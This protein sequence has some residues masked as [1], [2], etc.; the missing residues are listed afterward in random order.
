MTID[1]DSSG[2]IKPKTGTSRAKKKKHVDQSS[3]AAEEK[4]HK[5]VEKP[6]TPPWY[7]RENNR[8]RP[9]ETNLIPKTMHRKAMTVINVDVIAAEVPY[10]KVSEASLTQSLNKSGIA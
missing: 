10:K 1:S 4:S 6:T 8:T 2:Q 5:A 9:K 3:D 7:L